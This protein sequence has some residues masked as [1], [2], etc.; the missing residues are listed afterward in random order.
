[1]ALSNKTG[2]LV[3]S[4]G[5]KSEMSVGYSTLYGDMVG[6][7]APLRDISKT[8]VYRLAAW[9]NRSSDREVIP[10][11]SITRPPTAELRPDQLDVDSLPPYDEL[12][13][14]IEGYVENDLDPEQLIA[15]GHD[16]AVVR[17]VVRM[18]ER[19]EHKRRQG[20]I[21]IKVTPRAFGKDRRMPVTSRYI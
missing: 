9:R 17:R 10:N 21:G 7:F 1:M 13:P 5:N 19:A 20:P 11:S 15:C 18:I 6:G 8:W 14:I 12:D 16:P 4:T 2:A 3:L